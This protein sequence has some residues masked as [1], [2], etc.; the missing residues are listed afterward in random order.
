MSVLMMVPSSAM[1]G[2]LFSPVIPVLALTPIQTCGRHTF[3]ARSG[4]RGMVQSPPQQPR[5]PGTLAPQAFAVQPVTFC[6]RGPD[7]TDRDKTTHGHVLCYGDS[8][9]LGVTGSGIEY[10]PYGRTLSEEYSRASVG[11]NVSVCGHGGLTVKEMVA[12]LNGT[13]RDK[14]PYGLRADGLSCLL[15]K[16]SYDFVLIMAGT[17]DVGQPQARP[18]IAI[19]Q[20]ICRL[21]AACHERNVPTVCILPPPAPCRNNFPVAKALSRQVCEL[22]KSWAS[23]E[24]RV[25]AC[26]DPADFAPDNPSNPIWDP[27]HLHLSVFGYRLFGKQVARSTGHLLRQGFSNQGKVRQPGISPI[28]RT[29]R[30]VAEDVSKRRTASP[31][32]PTS[33][34][35]TKLQ[36]TDEVKLDVGT[37]AVSKSVIYSGATKSPP[38]SQQSKCA[39]PKQMPR[40]P[41]YTQF[42]RDEASGW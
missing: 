14:S 2:H 41:M 13:M 33:S 31:F 42:H 30:I 27:D 6:A 4:V 1:P 38:R 40:Q 7:T 34:S 16:E 25:L 26:I 15:S 28:R 23:A 35:F 29:N 5:T 36:D 32:P 37:S 22:L 10:E 20:D 24:S 3:C 18:A 19:F 12:G 9:T 8:L 17:N 39:S 11:C 21:H